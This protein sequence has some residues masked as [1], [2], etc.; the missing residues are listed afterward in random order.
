[1]SASSR[2]EPTGRSCPRCQR[3]TDRVARRWFERLLSVFMPVV[4]Y[5]CA[6][7][8]C[9][10]EGLL[11]RRHRLRGRVTRPADARYRPQWLQPARGDTRSEPPGP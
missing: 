2:Q 8:G 4:R 11:L 3:R 10:W 5:R 9:G 1:M 6:S 7:P